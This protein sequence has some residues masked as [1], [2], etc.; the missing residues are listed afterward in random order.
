MAT[1]SILSAETGELSCLDAKT[2]E[3]IWYRN[4]DKEYESEW[5]L[6]GCSESPLIVDDIVICTPG[7]AMTSMVAFNKM[8]GEEVWRTQSVGGERSFVS[9]FLYTYNG[10]YLI[11]GATAKNLF[12][13][14]PSN[15]EVKMTYS[16]WVSDGE[17]N[18]GLIWINIPVVKDNMFF[19]S[20]GYNYKAVM[21]KVNSTNT[22][23]E[24]VYTNQVLDNQHGG[25]V[26]IDGYMYGSNWV[27]NNFGNWVCLDWY[28]GETM[29][30]T[31]W[32]SKGSIVYA[33]GLLYVYDEK[34]GEMGI[35]ET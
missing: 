29:Y 1:G 20:M 11:I 32:T 16:Y 22:A 8:T 6:W 7:G 33:D 26:E 30:E 4:V 13:V 24:E 12:A 10:A 23:F 5:L 25:I 2:G 9:P 19:L 35:M 21:L 27:H 3:T 34:S 31:K 18:S 17:S 14:D 15:G 28:T